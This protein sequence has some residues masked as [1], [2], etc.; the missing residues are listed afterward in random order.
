LRLAQ[1][2]LDPVPAGNCKLHTLQQYYGLPERGAHTALENMQTVV[3]LLATVLRPLAEERGLS[4]WNAICRFTEDTWYPS[5]LTFGK[6]KGRA[7]REARTDPALRSW[8]EWLNG[9]AN[10]GNAAMGRWYLERL[11]EPN[12]STQ[13]RIRVVLPSPAEPTT[14]QV[15][16]PTRR[17]VVVFV[18]P[19]LEKLRHLV[20]EARTQLAELEARYTTERHAVDVTQ[21]KLFSMLQSRYQKRDQLQLIVDYRQKYLDFL[22]LEGEEGAEQVAE[23]YK[24]AKRQ[25]D[26]EYRNAAK[27]SE[28]CR[29][30][31]DEEQQELKSLFKELVRLYHPDLVTNDPAKQQSHQRLMVEINKARDEWD[32]GKLREIAKDPHGFM[33]RNNLGILN[34]DDSAEVED[35]RNLLES[36]QYRIVSTLDALN[37]LQESPEC[38]LHRLSSLHPNYLDQVVKVHADSLAGEIID[39]ET[40]AARIEQEINELLGSGSPMA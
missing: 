32:I 2:L 37:E 21:S 13:T 28:D 17:E 26:A 27:V 3:D 29:A 6:F 19:E 35:L 5:R 8:L 10:A 14:P 12:P 25:S 38:E 39:L 31:S 33:S 36:L 7:F 18:D 16:S 24:E 20:D 22:L 23:E 30:L 9:S 11:N 1:R 40:R 15:Q 34:F 4:S